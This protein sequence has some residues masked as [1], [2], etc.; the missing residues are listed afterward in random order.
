M[1]CCTRLGLPQRVINEVIEET[2]KAGVHGPA[3]TIFTVMSLLCLAEKRGAENAEGVS[4]GRYSKKTYIT[5]VL[6]FS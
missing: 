3:V 1:T 4:E 2:V 5:L 6:F